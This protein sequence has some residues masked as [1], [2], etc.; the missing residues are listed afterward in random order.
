MAT[1]FMG[2]EA[3]DSDVAGIH[4]VDALRDEVTALRQEIKVLIQA[5]HTSGSS[6]SSPDDTP[7][8]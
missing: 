2:Q 4:Q 7:K 5:N 8:L 1:F 3:E 6:T